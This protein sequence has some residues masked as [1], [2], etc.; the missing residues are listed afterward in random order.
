MSVASGEVRPD[1]T[2]GPPAGQ[3]GGD[4]LPP[5]AAA[6]AAEAA[7]VPV[8]L[9][10]TLAY[11]ATAVF[12]ALAQG[13]AQGFV[14][15]VLP[16]LAGQI[17]ATTT[18]ASWLVVAFM[19]PKTVVPLLLIKIRTQYGLR[20]FAEIG[21]ASFV[22]V[23][24]LALFE[25]D[26]RS[27]G[28]VQVLSGL[29]SAPLSTLAFL[30]MLE[31]LS[32]PLKMKIGLP[33]SLTI[34]SLGAPFARVI[35]P[36][37]MGDGSWQILHVMSLGMALVSL[38]LVF[39]LPLKPVPHVK[40]IAGM[41]LVSFIL[42]AIGFGGI[43]AVFVQGPILWWT[44]VPWLG[45]ALALSL[46]ALALAATIELHRKTP[47][48]DVHW[49]STGPIV[50]LAGV[51]LLLR[52]IL[53]EQAAGAPRMFQAMGLAADQLVPLFAVI[54]AAS[55]AGGIACAAVIKPGR[56]ARIHL[57][58]L[59][60]IALG[61]W[62]DSR[63]TIDT[64]P[65]QMFL[66]QSMIAFAAALFLPPAMM[67]GLLQALAK[68]PTYILSFVIV[69]LTTQA[70]GGTIGSGLFTTFINQRQAVHLAEL[71]DQLPVTSQIVA[72]QVAARMGGMAGVVTD[73]LLRQ[74]QAVSQVFDE[75]NAQ[76][77]VLAY[78]DAFLMTALAALACAA[79]LVLHML[80]DRMAAPRP[81]TSPAI[82]LSPP[83]TGPA[84]S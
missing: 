8:P 31:G 50:H 4:T 54:V 53:S 36:A 22:I 56:E 9:P 49:L 80:R 39:L 32:P 45:W 74:A 77:M 51:L 61:A 71:A 47:L 15:A 55:V 28:I 30:Y 35:A 63:S 60:L 84:Q 14:P 38:A 78:N 17:G 79:I 68:G 43:T 10:L 82:P 70:I 19:V 48:I 59:V 20:R 67:S 27:A 11:M 64:R 2:A 52:L 58:A 41:D 69:F 65:A 21:A 66:S 44:A 62:L 23:S 33:I 6:A 42:I 18:E 16:Q 5:A 34:L 57:A 72:A 1:A 25:G 46:A 75:A 73:P 40:V 26:A 12:L 81:P 13:L 83:S 29:A 37:L 24:A 7:F 76:S 3:D